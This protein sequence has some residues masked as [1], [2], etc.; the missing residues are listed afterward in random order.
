MVRSFARLLAVALS[1]VVVAAG[2][3]GFAGATD[4]GPARDRAHQILDRW[5]AA[6]AA[7]GPAAQIK[8]VSELTAQVGDWE[9]AVGDNNKR[10]LMAGLVFARDELSE[11]K[12][13]D[14]EVIWADGTKA[15]VPLLSAR[16]AL[17]AIAMAGEPCGD[18]IGLVVVDAHLTSGPIETTRGPATAPLWQFDLAGTNVKLTRVAVAN[19]V[20]VPPL[21]DGNP[22]LGVAIDSAEGSVRG[23]QLT[24]TFTGAPNPGNQSC[25]E[26]YSAEAVESELAVVVIVTRHPHFAPLG[27]GCS[28]VGARRTA[29]AQLAAPLGNRAVLD[30]QLGTPVRVDLRP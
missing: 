6:A 23:D 25:G 4:P 3:G 11:A 20:T 5:A 21:F 22:G 29:T 18:C 9:P 16:D 15:T 10:A 28:A 24:V 1:A 17:S 19:A 7:V 30:L 12:P 27:E 2:C 26:D 13:R 8:P 14:G